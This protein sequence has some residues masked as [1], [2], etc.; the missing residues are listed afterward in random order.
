MSDGEVAYSLPRVLGAQGVVATLEVELSDD[1]RSALDRS[2]Q[3]IR[4]A[5][6]KASE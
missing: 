6:D 1:E 2:I 3:V 4:E 5:V